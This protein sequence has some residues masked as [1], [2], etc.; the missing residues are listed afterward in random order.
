MDLYSDKSVL[1]FG[2]L[3]ALDKRYGRKLIMNMTVLFMMSIHLHC[4]KISLEEDN[5]QHVMKTHIL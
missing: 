4:K 2:P 5:L 1:F 3:L